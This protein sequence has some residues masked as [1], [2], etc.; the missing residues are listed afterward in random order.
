MAYVFRVSREIPRSGFVALDTVVGDNYWAREAYKRHSSSCAVVLE[1]RRYVDA[2]HAPG[3]YFELP[4]G[5]Y[6]HHVV[7]RVQE[8]GAQANTPIQQNLHPT[9]AGEK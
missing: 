5:T 1:Q 2:F 9:S 3:T 6:H 7:A 8:L 4:D